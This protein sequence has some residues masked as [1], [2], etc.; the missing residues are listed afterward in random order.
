MLPLMQRRSPR[1]AQKVT[2]SLCV[3]EWL[4]PLEEEK[5]NR[6]TQETKWPLGH[7]NRSDEETWPDQQTNT[8]TLTNTFGRHLQRANLEMCDLWDTDYNFDN[9]IPD[10]MTIVVTWQLGDTGQHLQFLGCFLYWILIKP[11]RSWQMSWD[12]GAPSLKDSARTEQG[13]HEVPIDVRAHNY[14]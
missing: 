2:S 10:I 7:S 3:T 1:T 4:T 5:N 6:A 9:W 13:T 14:V 12:N 8:N 11:I